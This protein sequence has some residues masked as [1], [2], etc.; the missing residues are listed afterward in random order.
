MKRPIV[1]VAMVYAAGL[2]AGSLFRLPASW[3]L[4]AVGLIALHQFVQLC[5]GR[6]AVDRL[7]LA[8][9]F[10]LGVLQHQRIEAQNQ[11]SRVVVSQFEGADVVRVEAR[12]VASDRE[13]EDRQTFRL[14]DCTL[15]RGNGE[16]VR[17]PMEIQLVCTA[18]AYKTVHINP[19]RPGDRVTAT[20]RLRSPSG[21]ANPDVFNYRA[22]LESRGIGASLEVRSTANIGIRPPQRLR[23]PI[24]WAI[25]VGERLRRGI[26][27]TLDLE[28]EPQT[29]RLV[30]S[31]VLGQAWRLDPGLRSDF[32]RCG[33]AHIF[34]VSGLHV[35]IFIWVLAT[36][37][38]LV[39]MRPEWRSLFLILGLGVF[40]LVVGFRASVF[41][42]SLMFAALLASHWTR[43]KIEP[44]TA[45][46]TVSFLILVVCPRA[47][48][49]AGFQLS[50]VCILSILVLMP[51]ID[52]WLRD[53][54]ARRLENR[55][56][57]LKIADPVVSAMT[58]VLAA[59]IGLMP[60]LAYYYHRVPVIGI[61]ANIVAAPAVWMIVSTTLLLS[62]LAPAVPVV[63][64]IIASALNALAAILTSILGSWA[65]LP[66]VSVLTPGWPIWLGIAYYAFLFGWAILPHEPSPFFAAQQRAR[67]MIAGTAIVAWV[68]WAPAVLGNE[69]GVLRATFLDVGQGDACV[70][71]LP[72]GGVVL[73]DGGPP[74]GTAGYPVLPFLES[75]GIDRL[76]AVIA[77][78]PDSDHTGGLVAVLRQMDVEWLLEG[79][80]RSAS[81]VYADLDAAA[82]SQYLR[83]EK[84]YAGDRIESPAGVQFCILNPRRDSVYSNSND[85]SLVVMIDWG[86]CEI[87]VPGD[88][89][90][91]AERDLLMS[92]LDLDCDILKVAHHGSASASSMPFLR[93]TTP[94]LAIVSCG[95]D[96]R[97]GHPAPD[98]LDRLTS[99]G[100]T[101]ARTDLEGAVSV[102][103]DRHSYTWS[104]EG[105]LSA[106]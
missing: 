28:L 83:R 17:S 4:A 102:R 21:L 36:V 18:E 72:R 26:E 10:L 49:Q 89:Q 52:A 23:T 40:C 84:V 74:H 35:G 63:A 9:L 44:L 65:S 42:A 96:N 7:L 66:A 14:D 62:I 54:M 78:H 2:A 80:G 11:A 15:R 5:R 3:L 106:P 1:I 57:L 53:G 87:L 91:R 105:K 61:F 85:K 43:Y 71:E 27:T 103:Y 6:R 32:T 75:L 79:P 86:D 55:P 30:R 81:Q 68:I 31:I 97:Y 92:G 104:V 99:A 25:G 12:L 59:Q 24:E 82:K 50:F 64:G 41:R 101:I 38:G 76:D 16:A 93:R 8:G 56:R 37:I 33:V 13:Y 95:L 77:T 58:V 94:L 90:G 73:I 29:A 98:V 19:P 39:G 46:A 70:V 34:A 88:I 20:G 60:F 48:A 100:A 69:K 47:L 22:Y 45:L 67:T 51:P